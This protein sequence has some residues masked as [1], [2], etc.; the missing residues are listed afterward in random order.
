MQGKELRVGKKRVGR[1]AKSF[2]QM[3]VDRMRNC[4]NIGALAEEL[5][6]H[7]RL[8]YKWRDQLE[9][10]E[11]GEDQPAK[12]PEGKLRQQVT[13]LQRLVA[14]KTLEVDF[15]KGALQKIEAR[16]R[17][18]DNSGGTASTNRSEK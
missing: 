1:Y 16:R 18:R 11:V 12:S 4:E 3:A 9:P 13:D 6:V 15:F 5:G 14:D 17:S 10:V 2:R 7:R 8:L